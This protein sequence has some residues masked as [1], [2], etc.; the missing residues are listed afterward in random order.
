MVSPFASRPVPGLEEVF[1]LGDPLSTRFFRANTDLVGRPPDDP[2]LGVLRD[3]WQPPRP[4]RLSHHKGLADPGDV[5]WTCAVF[6][7]IVSQR[8]IDLLEANA[9]TGW[10]T[11]PVVV[12]NKAK[13]IVPD[14]HGLAI[15]G[16][17]GPLDASRSRVVLRDAPAMLVEERVGY[18]F[19]E[20]SWD[21]SDLFCSTDGSG[22]TLCT[23][24][25]KRALERAKIRNLQFT[26]LSE[27]PVLDE[28]ILKTLPPLARIPKVPGVR[29]PY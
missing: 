27:M 19:D 7:L 5:V 25:V 17:C 21:G 13:A 23:V 20:A 4:V 18:H 6:P 16:R 3:E 22:V 2:A 29:Q 8:V 1:R 28:A 9:F 24:A 10:R 26:C 12:H 14:Y 15:V 11:Y